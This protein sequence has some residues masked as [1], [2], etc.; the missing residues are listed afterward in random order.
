VGQI[1]PPKWAKWTCQTHAA[2][3]AEYREAKKLGM[4]CAEYRAHIAAGGKP[5]PYEPNRGWY[6][7]GIHAGS[8][9]NEKPTITPPVPQVQETSV[10]PHGLPW[11]EKHMIHSSRAVNVDNHPRVP[12]VEEL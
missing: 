5:A 4:T 1:K 7:S 6:G 3:Q 11:A 2:K 10:T 8:R 12:A 9:Y